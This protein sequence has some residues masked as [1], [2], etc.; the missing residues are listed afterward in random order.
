MP[1][2]FVVKTKYG[3][4]ILDASDLGKYNECFMWMFKYNDAL[5]YYSE[6]LNKD[7]LEWLSRA[8]SGDVK[9]AQWLVTSRSGL[10]Y[11]TFQVDTLVDPYDH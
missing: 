4:V 6:D 3:D 11:E 7:Q 5:G 10:E 2:V 8:R 9:S 1:K